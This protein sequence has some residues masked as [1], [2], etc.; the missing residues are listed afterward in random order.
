MAMAPNAS[1]ASCRTLRDE[2][3][4]VWPEGSA[5][6]GLYAARMDDGQDSLNRHP[7]C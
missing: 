5:W 2:G 6:V 1:P 3:G 4:G 7:T